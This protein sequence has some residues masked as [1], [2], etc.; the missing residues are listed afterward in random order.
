M[1]Y[2]LYWLVNSRAI[3]IFWTIRDKTAIKTGQIGK[4][5]EILLI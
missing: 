3:G 2:P 4:M 5:G 1:E